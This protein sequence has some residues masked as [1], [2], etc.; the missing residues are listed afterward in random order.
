MNEELIKQK[1]TNA[2][3][4]TLGDRIISLLKDCNSAEKYK[5]ISSLFHS[6]VDVLKNEGII[7]SSEG[8]DV[9]ESKGEG[10]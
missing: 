10:K 5:V 1:K 8:E 7:I 3:L 6:L 9:K 2:E 4:S